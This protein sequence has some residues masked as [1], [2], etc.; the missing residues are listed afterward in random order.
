MTKRFERRKRAVNLTER[1]RLTIEALFR[2][3]YL[4]N[5]MV[6]RLFYTPST[7]SWCKQRMRRLFDAG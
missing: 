4:T 6:C 5:R 3:R 1:D 2:A 7:F